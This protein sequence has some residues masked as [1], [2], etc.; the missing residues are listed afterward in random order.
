MISAP[1]CRFTTPGCEHGLAA[2][3]L[4]RLPFSD[5]IEHLLFHTQILKLC[6]LSASGE[7]CA[8]IKGRKY[9]IASDVDFGDFIEAISFRI[10][11]YDFFEC[12]VH[13]HVNLDEVAIESL[14]IL[15]LHE[16]SMALGGIE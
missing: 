10:G 6:H 4:I 14:A 1:W 11:L 12:D 7:N 8:K 15:E 5:L 13:P 3:C 9:V 16:Y 2:R